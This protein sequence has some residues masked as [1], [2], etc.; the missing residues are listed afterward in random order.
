PF[1]YV[2]YRLSGLRLNGRESNDDQRGGPP[3]GW[4]Q[5]VQKRL[6]VG[7]VAPQARHR[8]KACGGVGTPAGLRRV[9][10]SRMRM[11]P[12]ARGTTIART[13]QPR[14]PRSETDWEPVPGGES[15]TV[16]WSTTGL[17]AS[18]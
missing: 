6:Y 3:I 5:F 2:S 18:S 4:P 16:T 7:F 8:R 14:I 11:S 15:L 9:T 10:R 17:T 12:T 1:L 13:I